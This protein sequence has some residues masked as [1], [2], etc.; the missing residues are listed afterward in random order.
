[1]KYINYISS[2]LILLGIGY[3]YEKLKINKIH[4]TNNTDYDLVSKYL[5]NDIKNYDLPFIWIY[6]DNYKNARNWESFKSR[7]NNE[8]NTPYIDLTI[9]T[10]VN[11][12]KNHFNICLLNDD[13][14][15]T[16][17]PNWNI[18]INRVSD[19]IKTKCRELGI[20]RVLYKYGG[21]YLPPGFV[22]IKNLQE[23]YEMQIYS[24]KLFVGE[25]L[26]DMVNPES[27]CYYP[28]NKMMIANKNCNILNEYIEYLEHLI[29]KDNTHE[30]IFLKSI[31]Y[32]LNKNIAEN[33]INLIPAEYIGV[34]D[35]NKNK[36][37]LDHLFDNEKV[38][39]HN[40]C[41]GIYINSCELLKRKKYNWFC[42][43][44]LE[45]ILN[46]NNYICDK[47]RE[48]LL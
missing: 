13:S 23:L 21:I 33:K 39:L 12:C 38:E 22:C 3:I 2:F 44:S 32:Y 18:D 45:E 27:V 17:L 47:L 6:I 24:N 5:L 29:S 48:H 25:F 7:T 28:S 20:A 41:Y 30:S 16:L 36:I 43:L 37:T 35:T 8:L 9:Q 15:K 26:N 11:K 1:M 14:F 4:N 40:N 46:V 31:G 19:P 42:Y 10:I 34:R